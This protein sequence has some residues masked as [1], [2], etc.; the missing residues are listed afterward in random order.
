MPTL[1]DHQSA[2]TVKALLIGN[3]GTGK[4]GA[5]A[6]LA[7]AGY[8]LHIADFDNG[9]D[10]LAHAIK[11]GPN[12]GAL[13]NV[14]FETFTD[15][16]KPVGS[17][18]V[19]AEVKAWSDSLKWLD[20]RIRDHRDPSHILVVDSLT[21]ATRAAM[22]WVLKSNNALMGRK[23]IQHWGAA[24]DLAENFLSLLYSNDVACNLIIT[25]HIQYYGEGENDI[26]QGFPSTSV[27]K[28]F[29]P[30][31]GRFFNAVLLAR[32]TG[33]GAG[34]KREIHTQPIDFVDLKTSSP[35]AKKSYP[36][37]TGLADY[38]KDVLGTAP[39]ASK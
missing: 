25:S 7:N 38:F 13:A 28:S 22:L 14:E 36:L 4:T 8:K 12:P 29:S 11:N 6:S 33:T 35:K 24:Q 31:V 27:G 21:F 2:A 15:K 18:L 37:E 3:S 16:F 19:P 9:L 39:D 10:Y 32:K 30:K 23:E 17:N 1:A 20:Q 34:V 26:K 5:L